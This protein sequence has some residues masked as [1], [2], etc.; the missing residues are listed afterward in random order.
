MPGARSEVAPPR[1]R[2]LDPAALVAAAD[3]VKQRLDDPDPDVRVAAAE[4]IKARNLYYL[5]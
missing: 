5:D 2:G 3:A 1:A 4:A